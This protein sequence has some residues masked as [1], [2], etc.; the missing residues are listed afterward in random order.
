VYRVPFLIGLVIVCAALAGIALLGGDDGPEFGPLQLG[1][2]PFAY[3]SRREDEFTV[4]ATAGHSHVIY[5]KSPD[6]VAATARRVAA[7][8]PKVEE[9]AAGAGVDPDLVEGMVFLESAG[10]P[11]VMATNDVEDAAGLT[12]ILAGTATALLGMRVDLDESRRLTRKIMRADRAGAAERSERLRARRREV[13]ERFDPDKALEGTG[14]YLQTAMDEFGREDLAVVSYHM[15]I[16]NLQDVLAAYGDSEASYTQL[17][18]DATPDRHPKTYTLLSGLGDDSKTYLWRVLASAEVMRL[19]RED[20]AELRR[21]DGLH[22]AKASAEEVLHPLLS[23]E[24]Y[25]TPDDLEAAYAEGELRPFPNDSKRYGLRRDPRM[26]EL[27]RRIDTDRSLYRGLRREAFALAVYIAEEVREI[28][29]TK[30]PLIVTSTVRD[31]EYQAALRRR[32][33]EATGAYSL[34]TTG[35]AF[36]VRRVYSSR[37]QA[38]AFQYML[39]RLQSLNLIAWVREPGAIHITASSEARRLLRS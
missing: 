31:R 10:R 20:R 38:A 36:D 4:R 14:R 7:Y 22:A 29:H 33:T 8:R 23:T 30:A 16:G 19:Y 2:D 32:N 25:E 11:E 1:D 27:A 13:D 34:H 18:F 39:D 9:V 21:L 28:A 17:Y 35:V 3:E 24:V 26:G 6:G 15:G 12:Q 37:R 5:E